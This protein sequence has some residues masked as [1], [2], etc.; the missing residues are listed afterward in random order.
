MK[1]KKR[2][3]LAFL[4]PFFLA[5]SVL[6]GTLTVMVQ[7]TALRKRPQFYAPAAGTVHLGD[8][9]DSDDQ[10]GAWYHVTK[11]DAEGWIHQSAVTT[12]KV[13]LGAQASVG[14][15]G[16]TAEEVTLAGKGFNDQVEQ[17]YKQKH[18]DLNFAAVDALVKRWVAER[19]LIAWMKAGTLIPPGG[20]Q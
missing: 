15:E 5:A 10:Q 7:Q 17:S 18:A 16:P 11:G 2:A 8:K 6:A 13:K 12:K 4:A 9:L 1:I 3:G 14:G 19:D 20:G